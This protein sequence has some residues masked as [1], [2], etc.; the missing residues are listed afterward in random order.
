MKIKGCEIKGF[1]HF[2][3][4]QVIQYIIPILFLSSRH[5]L[6]YLAKLLLHDIPTGLH[7]SQNFYCPLILS[8]IVNELDSLFVWFEFLCFF[9][10]PSSF[11]TLG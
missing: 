7:T 5:L 1:F 2:I 11:D 9:S 8:V 4:K 3:D 10:T 6:Q